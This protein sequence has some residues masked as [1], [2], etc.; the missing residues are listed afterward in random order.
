M[1]DIT[2]PEAI[3]TYNKYMNGVD[4]RD[5]LHNYYTVR[6]KCMKYHKHIFWLIFDVS[7]TNAY[8]LSSFIPTTCTSISMDTL[9]RFHI[10]LA[11]QLIAAYCSKKIPGC[12]RTTIAI[13][14][15][16]PPLPSV[17]CGAPPL[18]PPSHS[19]GKRCVYCKQYRN[20]P[21]RRESVWYCGECPFP[22]VVFS[23]STDIKRE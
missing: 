20:P 14:H 2:C 21:K 16:A 19:H 13:P 22:R 8:I 15:P 3:S 23:G 4:E 18:P 17:D 1:S 9:K 12:P 7:I 10:D 11:T 5:Q 6:L